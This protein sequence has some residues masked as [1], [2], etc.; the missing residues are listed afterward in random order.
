MLEITRFT[1]SKTRESVL[2]LFFNDPEKE[3]YLRQLEKI[4]GYSAGNIRREMIKFGS[5]GLLLSRNI[6]NLKLYRLNKECPV[7]NEIK[8]IIRKTIGIEG[9]LRTL[10]KGEKNI[11]YSFIYGSFAE[12]RENT[13]SDIDIIVVGNVKPMTV[14]SLFFEYQ[15][16]IGREIN[17]IVYA[18]EEFSNKVRNKNHFVSALVNAKKIFIK[19]EENEFRRFVQVRKARKA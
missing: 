1:R 19:G 9:A 10:L 7:Y 15:S 3:Y 11:D 14:K 17:S 5:D 12:G 6:G 13:L 4:T 16:K 8:G 18:N 2:A